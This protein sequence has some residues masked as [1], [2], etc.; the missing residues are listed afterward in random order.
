MKNLF[1]TIRAYSFM[2]A[3]FTK[4]HG[5]E[6][7]H[8]HNSLEIIYCIEGATEIL[9]YAAGT[10]EKR[11][12]M[13]HSHQFLLI[14]SNIKHSQ[15]IQ[16]DLHSMVLQLGPSPLNQPSLES[17][18]VKKPFALS[19]PRVAKLMEVWNDV[20]LL[21]DIAAVSSVLDS[22]IQLIYKYFTGA[23]DLGF[24]CAE[25]EIGLKTLLLEICRCHVDRTPQPGYN[26]YITGAVNFINLH[27]NR[28]GVQEI[29]DRMN[30]SVGYLS[31]LFKKSTGKTLQEYLTETRLSKASELLLQ[32]TLNVKNVAAKVGYNSLRTFEIAFTKRYGMSPL[33]Y[34]KTNVPVQISIW[35][36]EDTGYHE[37][38]P[39]NVNLDGYPSFENNETD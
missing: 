11:S 12:I 28:I 5:M 20:L 33:S 35:K 36:D 24:A 17:V 14:R 4:E 38:I 6:N 7:F 37:I 25:Y 34:R 13:I 2:N 16:T 10:G 26:R 32:S 21:D 31:E 30:I 22:V 29:A 39:Q 1:Q 9:Y 8:T 27:Y 3:H 18:I 23:C 15:H 19:I